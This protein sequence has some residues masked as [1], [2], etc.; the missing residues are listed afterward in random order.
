M[1]H[2]FRYIS[3]CAVWN[4]LFHD[5]VY[6]DVTFDAFVLPLWL[7]F[8]QYFAT[9]LTIVLNPQ[10]YQEVGMALESRGGHLRRISDKG[11]TG[12]IRAIWRHLGARAQKD[13]HLLAKM[14]KCL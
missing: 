12:G 6:D 14:Q 7:H 13:E 9:F 3:A 10:K 8:E 4:S 2:A 11:G 5:F 1:F